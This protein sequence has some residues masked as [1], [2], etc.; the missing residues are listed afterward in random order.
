MNLPTLPTNSRT[1]FREPISEIKEASDLLNEAVTAHLQED[2]ERAKKLIQQANI[3]AVKEW[4]YSLWGKKSP[5]IQYREIPNAEP[6]LSR[7]E[8]KTSRMPSAV[9]KNEL[10]KRDG[11]HCRFC[12]IPVIRREVRQRFVKAYPDLLIW[13]SKN[14]DQHAAFQTLWLQYDHILPHARGGDN[15]LSNLVIT[16]APCNYGRMNYTLAEV[17]LLNPFERNPISSPWDGLEQFK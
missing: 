1:C 14:D 5:Y 3:P 8:R 16:C 4:G 9:E 13:G 2:W 11:Y 17:G 10:L 6:I 15:D 12:G 7:S